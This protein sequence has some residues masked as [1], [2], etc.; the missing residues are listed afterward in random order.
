MRVAVISPLFESVPPRLYGGTER[1]VSWLCRGL[2]DSNIEV[3]LFASGD[4]SIEGRVV[5]VVNEALRLRKDPVS[6]PYAYNMRMLAMVAKHAEDFDV[7]HNHHDYWML[8]LTEMTDVPLLTTLHG[9]MDLPDIRAAFLSFPRCSYVSISDAQRFP[10]PQL[11]WVRTIHH[12]ID[13][14]DLVFQ[15]KPGKYLAFLGRINVEKRPEWA[16]EIALRSGVPLKIAAKIEGKQSQDYYDTFIKPHVDGKFIEYVGE[17]SETEKSEFLGN[18][19]AMTFP[20]DWPE[21]FGL[22][23]ME[24]LAC[25]TPVLA[26]PC[27]AVP[28]I[29]RDGVTGFVNTN[30]QALAAHVNDIP[31]ISRRA[32]REWV[33]KRFSYQRMTEDYIDVYRHIAAKRYRADRHRWNFLH[34]LQRTADRNP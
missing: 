23:V 11:R 17:I 8:P 20:I 7:I 21:P 22:V 27:G 4:S 26:R 5:P 1:V 14:N 29:L 33:E 10:M 15:E 19:L 6:D 18:A 9:R 34:P 12:G 31:K 32:C 13:V 24:S 3:V 30:I 16:I 2:T 28:E 25:G